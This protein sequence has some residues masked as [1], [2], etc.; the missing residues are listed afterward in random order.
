M[1]LVFLAP[2]PPLLFMGDEW[3]AS[4][5]FLFFSDFGGDLARAVTEGR[6]REFAAFPAFADPA[7][8]EQIPDPEAPATFA[9]S[10]LR[11]DERREP[12]H[13][14]MLAYVSG[15]LAQ[16]AQHVVPAIA[17]LRGED[18]SFARVGMCG[19]QLQW[20][21]AD[22][23][24][25]HADANLGGDELPGLRERLDG[26]TFAATHDAAYRDGVAPAWSVRWSRT[27]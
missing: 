17:G 25:L 20:K 23:S 1:A 13:A 11:W 9:A 18:A 3:S 22:G 7:K 21:L 15:L 6:R 8:R 5:P 2:S 19:I 4:T 26:V 10:Q 12:D 16:R 14:R 27:E 24:V